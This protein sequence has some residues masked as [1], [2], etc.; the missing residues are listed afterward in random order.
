MAFHKR[1]PGYAETPLHDLP[2]LADRLGVGRVYV[3]DESARLGLPSFKILGASWATYRALAGRVGLAVDSE[4]PL[5]QL[6]RLLAPRDDLVL[7][8]AT[9]GN[10]GRALARVA[11]LLRLGCS[12]FVP[13][14]T[15]VA[16]I[17]AIARETARVTVVDGSYDDAVR[18]VAATADDRTVV[19]SDTSWPGYEV[20]PQWI[21]E[22]YSTILWEAREQLATRGWQPPNVV[23]VQVGVGA[24]AASVA[25]HCSDPTWGR[26]RLLAVEPSNAAC[27]LASLHAGQPVSLQAPQDSVMVGL[28]CGTPSLVAWPVLSRCVD[29]AITTSD[30]RAGE[31]VRLL[32]DCGV[33]AGETGAAGLAGLL[34]VQ[35]DPGRAPVGRALGLTPD[36]GVLLL[37]TEG[38]T[39]PESYARTLARSTDE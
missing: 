28:N 1:L 3:K 30:A 27:L 20:V 12:I 39:D 24:L 2:A 6:R 38:P 7:A 14:G 13:R 22:G 17:D 31:A 16:R 37:C 33:A 32:R 15:S 5:E 4:A 18:A 23:V 34:E 19:V 25:R 29:A 9:D 35:A 21:V 36:S 11:R 8:A 10:H 26:P